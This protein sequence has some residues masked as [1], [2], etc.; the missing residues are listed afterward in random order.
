[1]GLDQYARHCDARVLGPKQVDFSEEVAESTEFH[2]WRK[3]PNL[4]G[5]MEEL[6]REKGGKQE[7][8][9]VPVRLSEEDLDRLYDD[10]KA[11]R[12]PET[13][14]FFFGKSHGTDDEMEEDFQFI[15]EAR[16]LIRKGRAVF[17][18]SW[19]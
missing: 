9:C 18:T 6:Y 11:G 7:F 12:L 16:E 10:I 3:H 2:Y 5:W 14:G 1:M 19:W 17:Y 13:S 15:R 4:Q 8:N